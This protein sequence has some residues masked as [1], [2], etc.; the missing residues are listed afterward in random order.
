MGFTSTLLPMISID[1]IEVLL[2]SIPQ[3]FL[4]AALAFFIFSWINKKPLYS[5]IGEIIL[6]VI[7]A[8][9]LYALFV[10]I[11]SPKTPGLE[12]SHIEKVVKVSIFF[13]TLGGLSALSLTIRAIRK[14]QFTALVLAIFVLSVVLFFQSTS[15]SKIK[16]EFN[17]PAVNITD[18]IK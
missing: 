16:F 13:V 3:Y 15:L 14:K 11:P 5:M 18:T 17:K 12:A 8:L 10:Y 1:T 7:G 2:R 9:M 6:T 4:F